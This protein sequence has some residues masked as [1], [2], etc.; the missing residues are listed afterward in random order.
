M[1]AMDFPASPTNGQVYGNYVYSTATG[2]WLANP[3]SQQVAVISPT[4]PTSPK[5]GDIWYNSDDGC[6]Y[7]YYYDGD[8]YQWVASRND[9]TFSSTLGPRVDAL[10]QGSPNLIVNG[11][12]SIAQRGTSFT[13]GSGS[14]GR[15]YTADRWSLQDWN[16]SAG[17]N[18]TVSNDT[19]IVPPSSGVY[20]SSKVATGATGLTFGSTGFL[21]LRHVVEGQNLAPYYGT[22]MTL[23]FY[24]RSSVAGTYTLLMTNGNSGLS[25][26]PTRVRQQEYTINTADTW[27]RKTIV[28]DMPTATSSGTWDKTN[29]YGLELMWMLGAHA[30]R[31]GNNY[32]NTWG[33]YSTNVYQTSSSLQWAT[34]AN[35]TFYLAGVQ[36]QAGTAATAFRR[37]QANIQAELAACQR[38]YWRA[39]GTANYVALFYGFQGGTTTANFIASHPVTMRALPTVGQS[40]VEWSDDVNFNVN[41]SAISSTTGSDNRQTRVSV[42]LASAQG[43]SLRVGV[44]RVANTG[45]GYVDFNAEL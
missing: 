27:E 10:E 21:G 29:G 44:V 8:S 25:P 38:Y 9:A 39:A 2:A 43:S 33:T 3:V 41:M 11:D 15:W 30:D 40:G 18:I 23:S 26:A 22:Q 28:I 32:Q 35:R 17:S 31:T 16:W 12:M 19:S 36:L 45:S 6:T 1:A 24:V 42:T 20:N 14:G 34:G 37:N 13:Y 5:A 7:V 4:A